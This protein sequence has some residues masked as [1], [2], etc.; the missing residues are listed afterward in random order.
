MN[1]K[2]CGITTIKEFE[3][4]E[5]YLVDF[6]GL[7]FYENSPHYI[8]NNAA[9]SEQIKTIETDIKKVGLFANSSIENIFAAI[10]EYDLDL[11]Q[12]CGEESPAFCQTI[13]SEIEIIK[14][15]CIKNK[16]TKTIEL[17]LQEYDDVCDYYC[18]DCIKEDDNVVNGSEFD[19]NDLSNFKIEK[20]FF[21]GGGLIKLSEIQQLNTFNHPD[22]LGVDINS[23]F[24][25]TSFLESYTQVLTLLRTINQINN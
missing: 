23:N 11:V 25:N 20:P 8:K 5:L 2:V 3:Q 4:L 6:V 18:F 7:H 17:Q 22:F 10:D 1:L 13:S 9:E 16:S 14:T 12:L 19:Y 21:I 15:I 24:K